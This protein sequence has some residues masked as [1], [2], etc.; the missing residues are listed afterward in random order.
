[1]AA[2]LSTLQLRK[3]SLR[4]EG[5]ELLRH[6]T[7]KNT[8]LEFFQQRSVRR[9]KSAG[10]LP[11]GDLHHVA[12]LSDV[13]A[14]PEASEELFSEVRQD[15]SG[16]NSWSPE[17]IMAVVKPTATRHKCVRPK[18]HF[19]R[20]TTGEANQEA[21]T[22]SQ[23]LPTKPEQKAEQKARWSDMEDDAAWRACKMEH[24]AEHKARWSDMEDDAP[25]QAC[26]GLPQ[27]C[28]TLLIR[29]IPK[30]ATQKALM[31]EISQHGFQGRFNFFYLPLDP[32]CHRNRGHAFINFSS[33][34][35]A[36][37]F[38]EKF[39]KS[40]ACCA[41]G[42]LLGSLEMVPSQVQGL[43]AMAKHFEELSKTHEAT[44]ARGHPWFRN[45]AAAK[46]CL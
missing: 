3:A 9:Q 16:G 10:D 26:S 24:K 18:A 1:M 21:S 35:A 42:G 34:E 43:E 19:F 6:A 30:K 2:T 17:D 8:F 33:P 4:D 37:E 36:Q 7:I 14:A 22:P 45:K 31:Q 39:D 5:R 28:Q 32:R 12:A 46:R 25:L 20:R 44:R 29:G 11:K 13:E 41:S 15:T 38:H 40:T 27:G 23:P